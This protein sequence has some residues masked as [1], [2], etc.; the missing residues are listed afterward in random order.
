M[1][2]V[3][4]DF[5]LA[6]LSGDSST[7]GKQIDIVATSSPGTTLHTA[8]SGTDYWDY[9]LLYFANRD[10]IAHTVTI[11]WGGTGA[12]DQVVLDLAPGVGGVRAFDDF[13]L[14]RDGHVIRAFCD[15][16][17]VVSAWGEVH[18]YRASL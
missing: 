7:D 12:S 15:T 6:S 17:S 4:G 18:T 8:T 10:S 16:T 5:T 13:R 9:V 3:A 14:L 11:E 2:S 1:A